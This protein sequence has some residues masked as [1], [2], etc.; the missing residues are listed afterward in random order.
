MALD[1]RQFL[2]PSGDYAT[3]RLDFY[4]RAI[5][6]AVKSLLLADEQILKLWRRRLADY[7]EQRWYNYCIL[8]SNY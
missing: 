8:N 3:G 4:H 7:F 6:K 5:T 2:R 1:L